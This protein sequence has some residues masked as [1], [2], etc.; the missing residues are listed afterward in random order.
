MDEHKS[1]FRSGLSC[2]VCVKQSSYFDS[3]SLR[4]IL[5]FGFDS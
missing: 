1:G 2:I 4:V 5:K 3:I